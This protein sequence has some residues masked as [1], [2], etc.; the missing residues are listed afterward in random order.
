MRDAHAL[1]LISSACR[2]ADVPKVG[3]EPDLVIAAAA[4]LSAWKR[5]S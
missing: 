1:D 3:E 4:D 5:T 2:E